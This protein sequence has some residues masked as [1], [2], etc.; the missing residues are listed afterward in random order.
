MM[1]N[2]RRCF[3][4]SGA[5]AVSRRRAGKRNPADIFSPSRA[6]KGVGI[7]RIGT[8]KYSATGW[9][10]V[11]PADIFSPSIAGQSTVTVT[12]S[13]GI[14]GSAAGIIIFTI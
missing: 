12:L 10:K 3:G 1:D 7:K 5:H 8:Y 14:T 4:P 11:N 13:D 2:R 9:V 6:A